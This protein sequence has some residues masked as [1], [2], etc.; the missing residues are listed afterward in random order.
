MAPK[1]KRIV[2]WNINSVRLR[3]PIVLRL[4]EEMKPD[5]LCL[6][7]IKCTDEQ[8]PADAIAGAGYPHQALN[9]IKAY[10][11]VAT[12]SREPFA[13]V[14]IRSWCGK[15]DGRHVMTVLGD[16]TE[17]HNFYIPAGGD[18]PDREEN[19]KF[20]HKLDFVAELTGYWDER[21]SENGLKAIM[22]GDLNIAPLETDVWSHKQLLKVVSHTPV[23]TEALTRTQNGLPWIDAV[24]HFIPAEEKLYSWW[25]YRARDWSAADKGRRLD[26]IWVTKALGGGMQGAGVLR[27]ARGWEKPSDHA[28][29]WL[30]IALD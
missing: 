19:D 11:G 13:D 24:R 30:D 27:D 10:H 18:V 7:E 17:L 22:V 29:V 9:G 1:A 5:V 15:E 26:H 2:T 25:S 12:V 14:Q 16:G 20:A 8:F 6:Q 28:P 4:L 21:R 23:E 3:L